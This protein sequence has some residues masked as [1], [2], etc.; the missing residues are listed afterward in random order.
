MTAKRKAV[1]LDRDGV[2]NLSLLRDGK[3]CPPVTVRETRIPGD[4][5]SSLARLKQQGFVLLV[6][7]NQPDVRRGVTTREQVEE[8]HEFLLSQ[9]PLDGFFACYHDDLDGCLCRKPRPGLLLEAAE[10]HEIDLP[11]S[12]MIG[13]RWRDVDA[14]SAAGCRTVLIDW[15]HRER[16]PASLPDAVVSSLLEAADW[17]L[18]QENRL[19]RSK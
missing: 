11:A 10:Q 3:P 15:H 19:G 6:V 13:D 4:V 1:F 16:A 18:K 2:L 12:Y 9:L 8:I 14:G 5:L 7:T 17:I